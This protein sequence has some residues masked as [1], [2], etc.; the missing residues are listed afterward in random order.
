MPDCLSPEEAH[1]IDAPYSRRA[2][3]DP[4]HTIEFAL[5][6]VGAVFWTAGVNQS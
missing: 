4:N 6:T 2:M 1:P 3:P 5:A